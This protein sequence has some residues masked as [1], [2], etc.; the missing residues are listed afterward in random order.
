MSHW[1]Y[2]LCRTWID[3]ENCYWNIRDVYYDRHGKVQCWGA[4][5]QAPHGETRHELIRDIQ[6]MLEAS[7]QPALD[8]STLKD[9]PVDE[10]ESFPDSIEL[11]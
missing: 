6:M 11:P 3:S 7:M 10:T 2:R 1:N 8:L 4:D 9:I 5:P